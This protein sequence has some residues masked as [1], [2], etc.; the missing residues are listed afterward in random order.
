[1][2]IMIEVSSLEELDQLTKKILGGKP[3]EVKAENPKRKEPEPESVEEPEPVEE[4]K[5]EKASREELKATLARLNKT[6][7]KNI[8]K[9]LVKELGYANFTL[10]PDDKL[11]EL[12]ELVIREVDKYAE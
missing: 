9:E 10:I 1:M 11:P 3:S 2:K 12:Q 6:A 5:R 7:K 8:A 4:P